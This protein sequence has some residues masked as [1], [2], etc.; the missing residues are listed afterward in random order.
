MLKPLKVSFPSQ[1]IPHALF[2]DS[3]TETQLDDSLDT[4][5]FEREKSKSC[6][7][8]GHTK[9]LESSITPIQQYDP[10]NME[11]FLLLIGGKPKKPVFKRD[12][13]KCSKI[14]L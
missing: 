3:F 11:P 10:F 13:I 12:P 6:R 1:R 7:S 8:A 9:T 5:D 14:F 4:G 2:C